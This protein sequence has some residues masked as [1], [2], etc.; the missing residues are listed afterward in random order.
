MKPK[1]S[2]IVVCLNSVKVLS[3]ALAALEP[4]IRSD[5]VEALVVGHWDNR[6]EASAVRARFREVTWLSATANCTVPQMR[7]LGIRRS[8]GDIVALLEDD[9]VVADN[10]C[11]AVIRAH[12]SASPAIGGPIEPGG[13]YSSRD[14]AVYFSEYGRFMAPFSGVVSALPG[15]NVSYKRA[16]VCDADENTGFQDVFVHWRLQRLKVDLIADPSL[17]VRN[18]NRWSLNHLTATPFHH[19]RAFAAKRSETFSPQRR[20][21][22]GGLSIALPMIKV[23]RV[24]REVIGRRRYLQPFLRSFHWVFLFMASWAAGEYVGYV[25]GAGDSASR[26]K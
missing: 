10:W 19:G 12:E 1:L 6:P 14:W 20:A 26:W 16:V 17:V 24:A 2:V 23:T 8:Q 22:Y 5:D 9:C 25:F 4:Q 21:L 13:H 11:Q 3:H 15:N 18:V 7:T